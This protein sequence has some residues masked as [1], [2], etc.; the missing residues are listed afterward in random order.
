MASLGLKPDH[1]FMEAS[2]FPIIVGIN[3]HLQLKLNSGV[4]PVTRRESEYAMYYGSLPE[5]SGLSSN[6]GPDLHIIFSLSSF[7]SF[8]L[9][10]TYIIIIKIMNKLVQIN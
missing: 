2:V 8:R 3:A 9:L 1:A 5:W 4:D 7:L 6:L 10:S